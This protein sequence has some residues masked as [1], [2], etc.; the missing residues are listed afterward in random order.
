MDLNRNFDFNWHCAC[1]FPPALNTLSLAV[2]SGNKCADDYR[3]VEPFSEP[4][5]R[6]IRDF[7]LPRVERVKAGI[8]LHS[9]ACMIIYPYADGRRSSIHST[10]HNTAIKMSEAIAQE[11]SGRSYNVGNAEDLFGGKLALK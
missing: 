8:S 9:Y 6:A 11:E 1:C 3:G 7:I 10:L 4:E 5:T 2:S